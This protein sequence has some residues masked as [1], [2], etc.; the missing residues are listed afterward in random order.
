MEKLV[1]V[2]TI[3]EEFEKAQVKGFTRTRKGKLERVNPFERKGEKMFT[4]PGW[5][6]DKKGELVKKPGKPKFGINDEDSAIRSTVQAVESGK[7]SGL[8]KGAKVKDFEVYEG[9]VDEESDSG[10]WLA[11]TTWGHLD[12]KTKEGKVVKLDLLARIVNGRVK[13]VMVEDYGW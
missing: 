5:T 2:S 8:P 9:E 7:I 12:I 13:K 6:R 3:G 4:P 11:G 1:S 10:K